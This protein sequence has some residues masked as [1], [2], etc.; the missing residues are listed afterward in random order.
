VRALKVYEKQMQA[1]A[2]DF[3]DHT[4]EKF[5]FRTREIRRD[6]G[7]EFQAKFHRH[8]EGLGVWHADIKRRV[9]LEA[10]NAEWERFY[11][12]A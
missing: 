3:I 11:N 6:N 8:I 9:D 2:I 7:L 4:I 12:F 5:P 10:R 1:N